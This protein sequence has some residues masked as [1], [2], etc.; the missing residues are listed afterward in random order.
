MS[1]HDKPLSD[2]DKAL[3][4]RAWDD[5]QDQ[6]ANGC[7][8]SS[9]SAPVVGDWVKDALG[10]HVE[11]QIVGK[12]AFWYEVDTGKGIVKLHETRAVISEPNAEDMP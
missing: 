10:S 3:I 11:G 7:S 1:D 5:L 8:A 6:I 9:C 4:D 12:G 2:T